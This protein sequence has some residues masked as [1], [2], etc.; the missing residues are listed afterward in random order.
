MERF[1]LLKMRLVVY[2]RC[3]GVLGVSRTRLVGR[4]RFNLF[5]TYH[6]IAQ[7][8]TRRRDVQ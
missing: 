5:I 8:F 3:F 1:A 7:S 6:T 2:H 4:E